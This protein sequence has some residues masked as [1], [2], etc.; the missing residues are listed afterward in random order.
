[1]EAKGEKN[2]CI[3]LILCLR[4]QKRWTELPKMLSNENM[5]VNHRLS[6]E[7]HSDPRGELTKS[8]YTHTHTQTI[9]SQMFMSDKLSELTRNATMIDYDFL[10]HSSLLSSLCN[11]QSWT[12]C[13]CVEPVS[14]VPVLTICSS[15]VVLPMTSNC[16][17]LLCSVT[18]SGFNV[19]VSQ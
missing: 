13:L 15:R 8:S 10:T 11:S 12:T 2:V 16:W 19:S 17:A 3:G 5:S 7:M 18:T 9:E 14:S 4:K 1:M 6:F